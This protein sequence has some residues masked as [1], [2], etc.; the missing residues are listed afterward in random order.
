MLASP[1]FA[2]SLQNALDDKDLA[3]VGDYLPK[4]QYVMPNVVETLYPCGG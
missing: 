3:K 1:S 2:Q 4:G